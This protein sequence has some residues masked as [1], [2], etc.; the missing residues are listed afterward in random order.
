MGCCASRPEQETKADD[1]SKKNRES[2][3]QSIKQNPIK[4]S[5][6]HVLSRKPSMKHNTNSSD[7]IEP[8]ITN[9]LQGPLKQ[10]YQTVKIECKG[11]DKEFLIAIDKRTQAKRVLKKYPRPNNDE[12]VRELFLEKVEILKRMAHPNIQQ[13]YESIE[14]PSCYYIASEYFNGSELLQK[15]IS[16]SYLSDSIASQ[17][18]YDMFNGL[19]YCHQRGIIHSHLKS[20]NLFFEA[21]SSDSHLKIANFD[22]SRYLYGRKSVKTTVRDMYYKAPETSNGISN[23]KSDIWSAGVILHIMITG[24]FPFIGN[25]KQD[26]LALTKKGLSLNS[27]Q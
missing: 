1:E 25:T 20:E 16:D 15:I 27:P 3:I 8:V 5:R 4:H 6:T 14:T 7:I 11:T 22:L 12:E 26:I 21:K 23:E 9:N 19:N 2:L 10:Y 17:C 24:K 18:M 13:T